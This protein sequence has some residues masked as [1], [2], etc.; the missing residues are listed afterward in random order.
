[1]DITQV[2]NE[3]IE[4]NSGAMACGSMDHQ[5]IRSEPQENVSSLI[6]K[7]GIDPGL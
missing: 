2:N 4:V 3:V 6:W 7:T 5:S 1:M